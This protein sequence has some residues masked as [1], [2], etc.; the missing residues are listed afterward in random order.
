MHI[1]ANTGADIFKITYRDKSFLLYVN[2]YFT[3]KEKEKKE[4]YIKTPFFCINI[5]QGK[6]IRYSTLMNK[7][8]FKN[9]KYRSRLKN[10]RHPWPSYRQIHTEMKPTMDTIQ[11][12]MNNKIKNK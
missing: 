10:R 3:K 4:K 11:K 7:I 5:K 6:Q 2:I 9:I 1:F 12:Y 8:R